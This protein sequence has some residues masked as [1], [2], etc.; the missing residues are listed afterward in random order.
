MDAD[1][2]SSVYRLDAYHILIF[3][4]SGAL[5]PKKYNRLYAW[6]SRRKDIIHKLSR[7]LFMIEADGYGMWLVRR[8]ERLI[9]EDDV[10]WYLVRGRGYKKCSRR[11]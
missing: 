1:D 11:L 7:T 2:F 8:L 5:E 6:W 3:V 4:C 10:E 9:G